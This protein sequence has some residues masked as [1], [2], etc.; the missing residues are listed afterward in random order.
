MRMNDGD[1]SQLKK[2]HDLPYEETPLIDP[3]SGQVV[4]DAVEQETQEDVIPEAAQVFQPTHHPIEAPP[5]A[6]SLF[7]G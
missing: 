2:D 5:V 6:I 4:P 3:S 7:Q 1:M